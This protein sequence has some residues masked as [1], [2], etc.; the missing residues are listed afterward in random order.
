V[1]NRP[2]GRCSI[3]GGIVSIYQG[4]WYGIY[5]PPPTCESCGTV[6]DTVPDKI[7]PM[8]PARQTS[9]ISSEFYKVKKIKAKWTNGD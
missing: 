3:C 4:S 8:S 2:I 1:S 6:A 9:R 7:I 5:P